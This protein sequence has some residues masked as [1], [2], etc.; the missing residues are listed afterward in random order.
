MTDNRTTELLPCPFC[1]GEAEIRERKV[2]Y[3]DWF[4]KNYRLMYRAKCAECGASIGEWEPAL[5]HVCENGKEYGAVVS[6]N[7]R[8]QTV[9]GMTLD[10]VRQMM[11][12]DAERERTCVN[13]KDEWQKTSF[14]HTGTSFCC[15]ECGAHYVDVECY[16][17]GL[18][19]KDEEQIPTNY[20]PNCGL[21][22]KR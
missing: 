12:R 15:S 21:R 16:Y 7:T 5:R 2:H 4:G 14:A 13:V 3:D 20:C 18:A 1:G 8:A 22:V 9:F 17:A 6:W 11:K 10:E 19:G